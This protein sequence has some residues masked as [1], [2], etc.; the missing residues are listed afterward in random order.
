MT[1]P[2]SKPLPLQARVGVTLMVS[3]AGLALGLFVAA[4]VTVAALVA[5]QT[6]VFA[7]AGAVL[8][9]KVLPSA[10]ALGALLIHGWLWARNADAPLGDLATA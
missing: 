10:F 2:M 3:L 1:K 9:L 7:P 4:L 8:A 5:L 6:Q